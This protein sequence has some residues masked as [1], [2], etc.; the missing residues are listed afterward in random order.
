MWNKGK[1]RGYDSGGGELGPSAKLAKTN[2]GVGNINIMV[3]EVIFVYHF[4]FSL[5]L[6]LLPSNG[7]GLES[8]QLSK[9]RRVT[10]R[11]LQGKVMVD[12]RE[13]YVKD[14]KELPGKKGILFK[15]SG[16]FPLSI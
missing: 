6:L 5:S 3:C 1:K 4:F 12:I 10:V 7:L 16:C 9:G 2:T 13:F 15:L 8:F 14:G 11:S